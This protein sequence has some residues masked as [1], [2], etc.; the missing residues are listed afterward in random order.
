MSVAIISYDVAFVE[1]LVRALENKNYEVFGD[2]LAFIKGYNDNFD[3]V[4]YDASSGVFAEDDLR[5]LV[6]KMKDKNLTYYILILPENP[7]D[8][9]NLSG[10]IKTFNKN[11]DFDTLLEILKSVSQTSPSQSIPQETK[12]IEEPKAEE[13]SLDSLTFD[14]EPQPIQTETKKEET[15]EDF[16]YDPYELKLDEKPEEKVPE[17]EFND[18]NLDLDFGILET[19][20]EE[21]IE[22]IKIDE[23]DLSSLDLDSLIEEFEKETAEETK[24][25]VSETPEIKKQTQTSSFVSQSQE[26]KQTVEEEKPKIEK[27]ILNDII[28]PSE[29]K[30]NIVSEG[31]DNMVANF[32][33]QISKEDIKKVVLEVARDYIKNDPAMHTIIDHLQIDF[34]SET[35]RELE[36]LKNQLKEKLR[37]EAEKALREEITKLIKSELKEYV[38]EIT[39][40]IVKE[41]LEQ[42]FKS[43]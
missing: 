11:K 15:F 25:V 7:I 28:K 42:A 32:N 17:L 38:A 41:K 18:I 27:V 34:Q 22:E 36:N 20:K 21:K 31:E 35:M 23:S 6:N 14:F 12:P 16:S 1:K 43:F 30:E 10:N 3:T 39:A 13:V 29:P 8:V 19:T 9:S 5:Y 2:S 26:E 40:Q 33:V 37:E 4:V 24:Q